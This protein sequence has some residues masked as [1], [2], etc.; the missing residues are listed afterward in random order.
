[1][2]NKEIIEFLEER[3]SVG[4]HLI[5]VRKWAMDQADKWFETEYE[6]TSLWTELY[7]PS[8]YFPDSEEVRGWTLKEKYQDI[9]WEKVDEFEGDLLEYKNEEYDT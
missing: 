3:E 7:E 8:E 4:E 1:M 5:N 6:N 2:T 9:F